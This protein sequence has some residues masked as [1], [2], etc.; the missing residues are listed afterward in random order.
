MAHTQMTLAEA[1][2]RGPVVYGPAEPDA[3]KLQRIYRAA[4]QMGRNPAKALELAREGKASID[5]KGPRHDALGAPFGSDCL[6]WAE[7]PA[8]IGLRFVGYADELSQYSRD[9]GPYGTD[10][11]GDSAIRGTVYQLPGR[12]GI[13]RF[14]TGYQEGEM[15]ASRSRNRRWAEL[16]PDSAALDLRHIYESGPREDCRTNYGYPDCIAEA[17][18]AADQLAE[19]AAEQE[20]EYQEAWQAAMQ[21]YELAEEITDATSAARRLVK[22][23]RAAIKSGIDAAPSICQALRDRLRELLEEREELRNKR[24]ELAD[25]FWYSRDGKRYTIAEFANEYI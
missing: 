22:D 13:S 2:K 7:R 14:V 4:R 6:Q 3:Y 12:K 21:W 17:A 24:E 16:N 11:Y 8:A 18:R 10:D 19:C 25:S 1:W 20:R 5:P 23:M 9:M 15:R